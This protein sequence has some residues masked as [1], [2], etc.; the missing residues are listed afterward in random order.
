MYDLIIYNL[1][2]KDCKFGNKKRFV[3]FLKSVAGLEK[4]ITFAAAYRGKHFTKRTEI[5]SLDKNPLHDLNDV[6]NLPKGR[7]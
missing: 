6:R 1:Q 5:K 2:L 3:L 7:N 4:R